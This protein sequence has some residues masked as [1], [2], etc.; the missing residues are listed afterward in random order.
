[1]HFRH[2]QMDTNIVASS[3]DVYIT[4]RA[5][6]CDHIVQQKVEHDRIIWRLGYMHHLNAKDDPGRSI[7]NPEFYGARRV[8]GMENVQFCSLAAVISETAQ[9]TP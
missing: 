3:R 9:A 8:L 1:M 6:N 4:S 7:M 5:K 2:R